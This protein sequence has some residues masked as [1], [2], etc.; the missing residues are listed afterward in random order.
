MTSRMQA[1]SLRRREWAILLCCS[2]LSIVVHG[3]FVIDGFGEPD[4]I[5]LVL[6]GLD[7][8]ETGQN[9]LVTYT[10][11]TSPIYLGFLK[12][13]LD[14]GYPFQQLG[15]LMNWGNV[16]VGGLTL[17]PLYMF[18]RLIVGVRSA[19]TGTLLYS[20][21]PTFW[22]A[23]I[24]G[25]PHLPSFTCFVLSLLLFTIGSSRRDKLGIK[26]FLGAVLLAIL[27][28]GLKADIILCF[29]AFAG[30][31]IYRERFTGRNVLWVLMIVFVPLIVTLFHARLISQ[32]VPSVGEWSERFPFT[33]KAIQNKSN[34]MVLC[35]S[36]GK[37]FSLGIAFSLAYYLFR[38]KQRRFIFLVMLW[39]MPPILFWGLKE[40]N[41]ARHMM[42]GY[43]VLLYLLSFALVDVFKTRRSLFLAVGV[44]ITLNYFSDEVTQ[45][46][47]S[48]S[49]RIFASVREM[50]R[51]I[52]DLEEKSRELEALPYERKVIVGT[53]SN[54]YI[55]WGALARSHSFDSMP[56]S[57]PDY[58]IETRSGQRQRIKTHY[59]NDI[60]T[61][62]GPETGWHLWA[63]ERGITVVNE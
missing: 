26:C 18:W 38:A 1:V 10:S 36:S 11:R 32:A 40:G 25:M 16:I 61:S 49:S 52:D 51:G 41:S 17:I 63:F 24:Y 29:G 27:S 48:P 43:C 47:V 62:V 7:W 50:N 53:W 59:V 42:A 30:V 31:M 6:Q 9:R 45:S 13:V 39:A 20:F 12:L 44:L 58:S 15:K 19:A 21:A 5:R 46:T 55:I 22:L 14:Y 28:V 37:F 8:H 2:C 23:N 54:P 60:S 56:G 3:L 4:A 57:R 34:L 33:L 35:K